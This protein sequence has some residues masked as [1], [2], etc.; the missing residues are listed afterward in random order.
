MRAR[1]L[2][3]ALLLLFATAC[4][5]STSP[6]MTSPTPACAYSLSIGSTIN[7]YPE[8]GSFPVAVT[9]TPASGCT[10]TAVSSTSWIHITE[11]AS[12]SG[13][14][15]FTFTIDPNTTGAARTGTLTVA[16]RQITVA[17]AAAPAG[18]PVVPTPQCSATLSIGTTING[19]PD[20]TTVA[21]AVNASSGCSWT[22]TSA[23]SWIHV[24]EGSSGTGNG[25]VVFV[26]DKNTG[27]ARKGTLTI[28]GVMVT[29]NQSG[30]T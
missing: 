23:D 20:G 25:T 16:G 24:T 19:Y 10:W 13:S 22:A 27:E 4:G 29:V 8:G 14:G 7:G 28:A 5:Q 3:A 6:S 21:V 15:T 9:T 2:G 12:G 1:L 17:Q 18:T 11:N 26:I 30:T